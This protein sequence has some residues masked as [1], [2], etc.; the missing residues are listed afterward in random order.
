MWRW[1]RD[2][3][4]HFSVILIIA[5]KLLIVFVKLMLGKVGVDGI[6]GHDGKLRSD[7]NLV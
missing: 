2:F 6:T 3:C 4:S 7:V 5:S 1:D